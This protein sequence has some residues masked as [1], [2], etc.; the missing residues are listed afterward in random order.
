MILIKPNILSEGLI[1]T[2]QQYTRDG[3]QP[4]R[5]NFFA[6]PAHVVGNSNAIFCF[7][8]PEDIKNVIAQELVAGGAF[9]SM[10][11]RWDATM[12]LFSR[13]SSIPWH[14]DSNHIYTGTV[15][16]NPVWQHDWGGYFAYE[17]GV[18]IKCIK[19]MFNTGVFMK[20]PV[21]HTAMLTAN[22]APFRESLQLFVDE[23]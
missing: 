12:H 15:Y 5:T 21:M 9:P 7:D 8:L 2:L 4:S 20:T 1:H 11:K 14:D 16:L 17:D 19:P 6:F 23:F 3:K 22:N 13:N 18:E 10:P